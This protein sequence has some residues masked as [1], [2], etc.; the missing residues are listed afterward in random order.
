MEKW[1]K[2]TESC[3]TCKRLLEREY[4]RVTRPRPEA[5]IPDLAT[6]NRGK[7]S[8]NLQG[9]IEGADLEKSM[10]S[11]MDDYF[12]MPKKTAIQHTGRASPQSVKF[13]KME[14]SILT[15][16]ENLNSH[17]TGQFSPR[18]NVLQT[19]P[20]KFSPYPKLKPLL[21]KNSRAN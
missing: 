6:Q 18:N 9:N 5:T 10:A 19:Q 14:K 21:R 4:L 8:M 16:Q 15:T 11:T 2:Y 7:L 12:G 3:P 13:D 17:R 1:L 20:L